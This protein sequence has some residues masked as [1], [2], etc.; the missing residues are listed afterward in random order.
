MID[1]KEGCCT[2][3]L[4]NYSYSNEVTKKMWSF[5]Q[6]QLELSDK[7]V[8]SSLLLTYRPGN[9]VCPVNT[10][11]AHEGNA[12]TQILYSLLLILQT[13]EDQRLPGACTNNNRLIEVNVQ[14]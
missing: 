2:D 9:S 8:T 10:P 5:S 13:G 7:N 14:C 3:V 12:A 1:W 4:V 6:F 11:A